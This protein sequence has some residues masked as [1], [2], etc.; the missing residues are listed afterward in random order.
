MPPAPRH[1]CAI[2]WPAVNPGHA[3]LRAFL[4]IGATANLRYARGSPEA[5]DWATRLLARRPFKVA[6]VALANKMARTA[7]ALLVKGGVYRSPAAA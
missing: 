4:V 2:A 3:T 6:A 7:W 1:R 5:A